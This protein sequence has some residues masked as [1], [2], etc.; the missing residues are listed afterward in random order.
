M[1]KV[2]VYVCS[3][4]DTRTVKDCLP[5]LVAPVFA[6]HAQR[7]LAAGTVPAETGAMNELASG[8]MLAALL[9]VTRDDQL[10]FGPYGKPDLTDGS[11]FFNISHSEDLVILGICDETVGVDVQPVPDELDKYTIL[12]LGRALGMPHKRKADPTPELMELAR[13]P[14]EWARQWTRVEA[15]L[16]GIGTGFG[17]EPAEYLPL[18]DEWQCAWGQVGSDVI[19]VATRTVPE[20]IMHDFDI[21]AWMHTVEQATR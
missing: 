13:T 10:A 1:A 7:L 8:A 2:D 16:K 21:R 19:C 17:I 3:V 11:S 5:A 12:T 15:I 20:I 14:V 6:E 18:M 9:G 4:E